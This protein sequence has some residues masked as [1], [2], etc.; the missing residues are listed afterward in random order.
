MPEQSQG[1]IEIR[2]WNGSTWGLDEVF[3]DT[4]DGQNEFGDLQSNGKSEYK[5]FGSAYRYAF[6][7]FK[8]NGKGYTIQPTDYVGEEKLTKGKYTYKIA[9][10]GL[11]SDYALL[12]FIED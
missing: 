9:V 8:I 4:S 2:I 11:N 7:S 1:D 6:V 10:T 12:E 3:V 5:R